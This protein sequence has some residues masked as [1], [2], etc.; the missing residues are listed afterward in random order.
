[1]MQRT[2]RM[3]TESGTI[4]RMSEVL[5][6]SGKQKPLKLKGVP[7]AIRHAQCASVSSDKSS[8]HHYR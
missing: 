5:V 3:M 1:M 2:E 8:L 6:S 4:T 7:Q